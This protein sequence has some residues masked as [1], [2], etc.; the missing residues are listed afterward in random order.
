MPED[1][2]T[3]AICCE[4]SSQEIAVSR[5]SGKAPIF[6]QATRITVIAILFCKSCAGK[7]WQPDSLV[8]ES[9][10]R[11][12]RNKQICCNV[13]QALRERCQLVNSGFGC[14]AHTKRPFYEFQSFFK[15]F[16]F[17]SSNKLRSS[18]CS[19]NLNLTVKFFPG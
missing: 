7:V 12:Q 17:C 19:R 2:F 6:M 15:S 4:R 8:L 11:R 1:A 13:T 18:F 5:W 10:S 14:C 3:E 16:I 9:K